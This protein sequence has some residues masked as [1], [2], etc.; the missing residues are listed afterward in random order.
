MGLISSQFPFTDPG[1]LMGG[2]REHQVTLEGIQSDA[3]RSASQSQKTGQAARAFSG[4]DVDNVQTQ[5]ATA[6]Q[7]VSATAFKEVNFNDMTAT[8][9][10]AGNFNFNYLQ[11]YI[12][13]VDAADLLARGALNI[14]QDQGGDQSAFARLNDVTGADSSAANDLNQNAWVDQ[15]VDVTL[16]A[17]I[18]NPTD[19]SGNAAAAPF[20]QAR[21]RTI[22]AN[23]ENNSAQAVFTTGQR[24]GFAEAPT[25]QVA[26]SD[27][28]DADNT[29]V[30]LATIQQTGNILSNSILHLDRV[31]SPTLTPRSAELLSTLKNNSAVNSSAASQEQALVQS[32]AGGVNEDGQQTEN[33][34]DAQN[35][36]SASAS[37]VENTEVINTVTI[38]I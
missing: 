10:Q 14:A 13:G 17:S 9:P 20:Q 11:R 36:A 26:V 8:N 3:F 38:T 4:A 25:S 34:G 6:T 2:I 24:Q 32:A 5:T 29:L 15:V 37:N 30:Q 12:A 35:L 33:G 7:D 1:S 28:A 21:F 16:H 23:E 18:D 31:Q 22:A 27:G 19:G